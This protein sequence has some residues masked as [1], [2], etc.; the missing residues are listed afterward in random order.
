MAFEEV[1]A[2]K[3]V[4]ELKVVLEKEVGDLK[5]AFEVLKNQVCQITTSK[6]NEGQC[7]SPPK[8]NVIVVIGGCCD[9]DG[10]TSSEMFVWSEKKWI[11]FPETSQPRSGSSAVV[12]ENK[13]LVT[14]G[15]IK[16]DAC[17]DSIEAIHFD[18][19]PMQWCNFPGKLPYPSSTHS[20]IGYQDR[21]IIIGGNMCSHDDICNGIYEL[22]LRPPYNWN[23]LSLMPTPRECH[24]AELFGNKILVIG[25]IYR[26]GADDVF[27]ESVL[28]FDIMTNKCDEIKFLS[29]GVQGMASVVWG[30]NVVVIGGRNSKDQNLNTVKMFNI[31][32]RKAYMLPP[33]NYKRVCCTAVVINNSIVIIGGFDNGKPLNVVECFDFSSYTWTELPPMHEARSSPASVVVPV[34]L[35][36]H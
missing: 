29:S 20:C 19:K 35:P 13:I 21:L 24:R 7:R 16:K 11:P 26:D 14:G 8:E 4:K 36:L 12:F 15:R 28:L 30:D 25:G 34:S 22:S 2:Q 5:V 9:Q 18:R 33:M 17:T 3:E 27:E 10:L 6:I 23:F 1:K 31:K 32:T